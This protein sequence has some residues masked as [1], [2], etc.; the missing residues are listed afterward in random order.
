[1]RALG[2]DAKA[3]CPHFPWLAGVSYAQATAAL[4]IERNDV[5]PMLAGAQDELAEYAGDVLLVR[6]TLIRSA[7]R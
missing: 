4:A 6:I 7:A 5:C 3:A 2:P 1:M